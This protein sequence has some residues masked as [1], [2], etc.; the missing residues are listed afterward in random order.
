M[1]KLSAYGIYNDLLNWFKNYL[2]QRSQAAIV[3]QAL[4][5]ILPLTYG[6]MQG[7]VCGPIAFI[8]YIN[9]LYIPERIPRLLKLLADNA[10]VYRAIKRIVD[11]LQL[12]I[13]LNRIAIWSVSSQL[14][15][16]INTYLVHYLGRSKHLTFCI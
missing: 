8:T 7:S 15:L 13:A 14:C 10:K 12:Q 4:S 9:V 11:C 3:I 16:C 5:N 2:A 1:L 6:A